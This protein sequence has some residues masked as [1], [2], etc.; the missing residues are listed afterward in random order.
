M[1]VSFQV[2]NRYVWLLATA[3]ISA[4]IYSK[5]SVKN[6]CQ[7]IIVFPGKPYFRNRVISRHL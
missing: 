4:E 3:L 1:A 7:F 2:P 6:N 5:S